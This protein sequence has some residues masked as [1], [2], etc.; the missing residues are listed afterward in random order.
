MRGASGG[1]PTRYGS[2]QTMARKPNYDFEK[3]KKEQERKAKKDAK[4]ADRQQRR[5]DKRSD[6][7]SEPA[8]GELEESTPPEPQPGT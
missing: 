6:D 7:G 2:S 1:G 4:R 8:E 3:R 5:E